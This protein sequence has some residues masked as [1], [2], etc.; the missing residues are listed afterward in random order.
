MNVLIIRKTTNFELHGV[1][2][3]KQVESGHLDASNLSKLRTAHEQHYNCLTTV[4]RELQAANIPWWEITRNEV[5]PKEKKISAVITIGGDGTLLS[6]SH[7][8]EENIKILGVRSSDSSV[9]YLCAYDYLKAELVVRDLVADKVNFAEVGR[10]KA[11]IIRAD[12]AHEFETA[13]VLNEFL[14][15]NVSPAA[16][17][18]YKITLNGQ[19]EFQ[20]SSGI[21]VSTAIGSSA[22][23]HAAG[24]VRLG[25]TDKRFQYKVRELYNSQGHLIHLTGGLF[26]SEKD[27][28]IIENRN[29]NALLAI[30][31]QHGEVSLNFGDRIQFLVANPLQ[32][33]LR[34]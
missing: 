7:E 31:G 21:W 12:H 22:A 11:K 28:L 25:P 9:G 6:A 23:I 18:R 34:K 17:S 1:R 19:S 26:D 32:F 10:I 33:A 8:I 15:A 14:F 3:Q 29:E 13:P 4:R 2:T 20:K 5:W 30:D 27:T 16:T 24:G